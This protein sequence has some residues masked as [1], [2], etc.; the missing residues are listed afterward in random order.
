[1]SYAK[2]FKIISELKIHNNFQ[3]KKLTNLYFQFF[4]YNSV[5]KMTAE[6][7]LKRRLLRQK[8]TTLP[9]IFTIKTNVA[10]VSIILVL[11]GVSTIFSFIT[12][13]LL[14]SLG[15]WGYPKD[16]IQALFFDRSLETIGLGIQGLKLFHYIVGGF[17]SF[18]G[19]VFSYMFIPR[20]HKDNEINKNIKQKTRNVTKKLCS[21]C[22]TLNNQTDIFCIMCNASLIVAKKVLKY[23]NIC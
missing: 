10:K 8:I 21:K 9:K 23:E 7:H 20:I 16:F 22:E 15:Y 13:T 18:S 11:F 2:P 3:D 19:G 17:L 5:I 14:D 12:M 6:S 1:M 4:L